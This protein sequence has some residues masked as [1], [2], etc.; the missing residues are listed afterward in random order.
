M[1]L[2]RQALPRAPFAEVRAQGRAP[3]ATMVPIARPSHVKGAPPRHA[4][5]RMKLRFPRSRLRLIG[6]GAF[7]DQLRKRSSTARQTVA[8]HAVELCSVLSFDVGCPAALCDVSWCGDRSIHRTPS[9]NEFSASV[10]QLVRPTSKLAVNQRHGGR[11][12]RCARGCCWMGR[13]DHPISHTARI[14][15]T[16]ACV[17]PS[18]ARGLGR[19]SGPATPAS[20]P[21]RK[22]PVMAGEAPPVRMAP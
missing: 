21:R 5:G 15:G 18:V 2:R 12:E 7:R 3:A 11:A 10:G 14:A 1:V 13:A 4:L 8:E 17:T 6:V 16:V 9:C 20:P 22:A 19:T